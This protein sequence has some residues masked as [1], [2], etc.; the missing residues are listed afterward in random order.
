MGVNNQVTNSEEKNGT[1]LSINMCWGIGV[2]IGVYC[3]E[4]ISGANLNTAVT[5]AHCVY[6][7]LPWW[8][9]PGYMISQLLGAFIGAFVIYVMQY[10]N[11]NVIDPNREKTQSSFST[12]PSGN[13]SNYTAF[14]TEFISS[15][16][17]VLGVYA[18]T[19]KRNKWAGPVGSPFAFCLL[20]WAIGMA[21][22]MN[23]GYAINPARDFGP[24]LFTSCAGW[25]SKVFTLRN[26]YFWIPIVG[27]LCGGVTGAG[28]YRLMV[29]MHHPQLQPQ[30]H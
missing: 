16:F 29:E 23:T 3:S 21:F 6:G 25:G 5:F 8:K 12:Y 28:L 10:Q 22:G 26:H 9:A 1:W 11:L 24:R 19:D 18:I 14:Y 17:N 15:A 27:P 20:T 2:L 4:G 7:R 30:Q 13:I